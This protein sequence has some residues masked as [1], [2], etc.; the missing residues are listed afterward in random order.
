MPLVHLPNSW[1]AYL[2]SRRWATGTMLML[3]A[4]IGVYG[5]AK[6][7]YLSSKLAE[8][9]GGPSTE[10][11]AAYGP[12]PAD[13]LDKLD[14]LAARAGQVPASDIP[15]F[16]DPLIETLGLESD[17]MIRERIVETLAQFPG[18]TPVRGFQAAMVDPDPH[19]RI[20]VCEA[21]SRRS[22]TEA[23]GPLVSLVNEDADVDVRLAAAQAL[24]KFNDTTSLRALGGL[25]DENDP[26]LQVAAIQSLQTASGQTIGNSVQQWREYLASRLPTGPSGDSTEQIARPIDQDSIYR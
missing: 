6:P 21:W 10:Y 2:S 19:V 20:A 15:K 9:I 22:A 25:L 17:P 11:K 4:A 7:N 24:G 3:S 23:V 5:C 12:T 1:P 14:A 8:K 26:T 16:C 18:D 13:R